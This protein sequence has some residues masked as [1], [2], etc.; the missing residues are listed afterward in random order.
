MVYA[1]S[2]RFTRWLFV[3]LIVLLVNSSLVTHAD[4]RTDNSILHL[5]KDIEKILQAAHLKNPLLGI[6]IVSLNSGEVVYSYNPEM[7]LNPASNTKLL[8]S[9]TAL[10][11]LKP[12]YQ[13]TTSVHTNARIQSGVLS[14]DVYLKGGGDPSLAYEGLL[15]LAQQLYNQGIR[16]IAGN[17]IGDDSF[18]DQE[19]E[20]SGW[21][22]FD[23]A[24][25]GRISA[26]SL[27]GNAVTLRVKPASQSGAAPQIVLDPPTTYLK[28]TNKAKTLAA[29]NSISTAFLAADAQPPVSEGLVIQGRISP[30]SVTGT[31]ASVYVRNPSLFT[32][33]TF[34]DALQQLGITVKGA[35]MLGTVPAKSRRLAVYASAPLTQIICESNKVSNNF[36]AEQLLKTLGAEVLG[37]PGTTAKGIQ[38][39]QKFLADLEIPPESYVLEN[40]SGL[41]RNNRLSPEQIVTVL[42]YMYDRFE[43][44]SEFLASLAVAGVDGTLHRRLQDTQ[45]ERRLRAKTG[46]I[47]GVSCLSGYA[48]SK[49]NEIFAF[50]IMLNDYKTGGYAAQKIQNE[51]G[52]LLTE[53]YRPTYNAQTTSNASKP[54]KF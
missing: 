25:S 1:G 50:S 53:F 38:V 31:F 49:D 29:K 45:A 20:F 24:Y 26:L 52:L 10:V 4:A 27:N 23:H 6:Q 11:L 39:I 8:T 33:T 3:C 46:A 30:K 5:Q 44:R 9:A 54:D 36:V 2:Y 32:T 34:R 41:S 14:G 19:R 42:T 37:A 48:A 51:I 28:I 17:V 47:N 15:A 43:V 21:Q 40:G 35:V 12:E 18:F 16:T 13:F 7:S 22:D